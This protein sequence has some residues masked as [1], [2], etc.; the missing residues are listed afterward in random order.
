MGNLRF[1]KKRDG[2][3]DRF[4]PDKIKRAI[5]KAVDAA[6]VP[7][8]EEATDFIFKGVMGG[9]SKDFETQT[10]RIIDVEHIIIRTAKTAGY[11]SVARAYESY[12][13]KRTEARNVLAIATR[14]GEVNTTDASLLIESD[15]SET[16]GTWDRE[17]IVSQL[18]EEAELARDLAM[19][20]AKG[21]ENLV[22]DMYHRGVRRFNTRDIRGLVDIILRKEGLETQRRKQTVLAIPK[23]DVWAMVFSKNQENSNVASNN[24]EALNLAIA[25]FIQKQLALD[26]V[27]SRE[28]TEAHLEGRIHIHDLG[29]PSRVY[30]SSHSLEYLKKFG[31]NELLTNLESKSN[32]P[33]SAAVLNQHVQTALASL[34]AHY[35]GALGFGFLNIFYPP[36]LNRPVDVVLGKVNGKEIS[37]EKT[38]LEKLV[39]QGALTL[40]TANSNGAIYFEKISERKELRN[41]SSKERFQTAQ[42][43]IFAASQN[44]FSRG[45]Q[46]LFIDFNVHTGV[47]SYLKNVPAIGPKGKYMIQKKDGSVEMVDDVPRFY[48]PENPDDP[49]NGDVDQS[50]ITDGRALVY[51][52]FEETVQKFAIDLL[53]VWRRGD[54]DG[55]NFH[56]PKCDFHVD[57]D[58]FENPQQAKVTDFAM[59]VAAENGSVYFMFDRG[60]GAVLTQCCRL[61][62]KIEDK[63]ILKHPERLRFCGF[64]NVTI[65]LPQ[66]AYRGK[67]LEGTLREIDESMELGFLAHQQKASLMQKLLE[68]DGSPMRNLG[69]PSDDGHPYIDLKKAT[70][71]VGLIGLNELVQI[72]TGHQLHESEESYK[73]GLKVVAHMNRRI[74]EKRKETGLKY[75]LEES[76]AESATRRLAKVDLRNFP[77]AKSVIKGTPED[78]YY[79]NSIHFAPNA[80]V[81]LVDR[82]VGQSSFHDMIESG[83]IIHAYLGEHRPDKEAIRQFVE[84]TLRNTRCTQLVFSPTFTEC[85]ACGTIMNGNK[86]LCVN[87]GCT[88]HNLDTLDK[89]KLSV[90]TRIVGYYSKLS[91]W[92]ASQLQMFKDREK[93]GGFYAGAAGRNMSWLYNPDGHEKL[94][95]IQFA[96]HNCPTCENVRGHVEKKIERLGLQGQVD[97]IFHYL[98]TPTE[99][100][101][102][103]AA[104]YGVPLDV[105]P[106]LVVAGKKDYWKKITRYGNKETG[107]RPDLIGPHEI[108]IALKEKAPDYGLEVPG[109]KN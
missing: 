95:V 94:T 55:R 50:K 48:N 73:L 17:K 106:T 40:D 31:L 1:I 62:E 104:R 109:S 90:I 14:G 66:A 77:D 84:K 25:E 35:A 51:G 91:H 97:Y 98:D 49:R 12:R 69:A 36:L 96:K 107:R 4:D 39:E 10:P 93:A 70:Y 85:D 9:L 29:Y 33:N 15:S 99:E 88:N 3:I 28:V 57:I 8:G 24:P 13:D 58:S 79:T 67:T 64:Q 22:I 100:G 56:F 23:K 65:N 16:I 80:D 103:A 78:P 101:L 92:N 30:C 105:F 44:A 102:V 68:T 11:E 89:K 20:I 52:D 71:I 86:E 34:Q 2:K 83:A 81:S 87:A 32:S 18:E 74:N 38:D 27:F 45:G 7:K 37:M 5:S 26:D 21:V 61:K 82:I 19:N 41:L 60:D 59:Q 43:L 42:N 46:T 54:R 75:T 63:E 76:P 6:H 108:E 47:P 53:E 72:L